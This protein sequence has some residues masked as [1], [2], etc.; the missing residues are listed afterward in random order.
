MPTGAAL[1]VDLNRKVIH[2]S[3]K[4]GNINK[5]TFSYT[6]FHKEDTEGHRVKKPDLCG[7]L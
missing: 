1:K 5:I 4:Y 2:P 6:E 7:S 3:M